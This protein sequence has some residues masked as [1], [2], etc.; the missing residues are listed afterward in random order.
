MKAMVAEKKQKER[1][2]MRTP[3]KANKP[4]RP[5]IGSSSTWKE[6]ELETFKVQAGREVDATEIIPQKWLEFGNL[7]HYQSG[8]QVL[9]F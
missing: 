6:E 4:E 7:N 9:S 5:V 2:Q 1:Q 3:R 8:E